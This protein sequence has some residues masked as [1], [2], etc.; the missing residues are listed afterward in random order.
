MKKVRRNAVLNVAGNVIP[1]MAA[2]AAMPMLLNG[3]GASRMGI[4]TLAL[5]LFGFAGIFD[6]GLGRALTRTIAYYTQLG[7]AA[8]RIAP[9]LRKGLFAVLIMGL[10]WAT[11]LA[12]GA[13]WLLA[14]VFSLSG[15]LHDETRRGL[16]ILTAL[17]PIA[18][19]STSLQGALEG[20]QQFG[21]S[22]IIRAPVGVAT[23]LLPALVAQVY[24]SLVAV[25]ASLAIVRFC[26]MV[27][28]LF[29]VVGQ[30]PLLA[31]TG[32]EPLSMATMWRYTGWLSISNIVGPLMVYGDRYYL[33]SILPP[34]A[35]SYYTVP[36]DTLFR[37][38]ALPGS[39]L[40][41]A[42]PALTDAQSEPGNARRFLDDAG[43]LLFFAW[44]VP[45]SL[46]AVLLPDAL[47][48]WLGEAHAQQM[49]GTSRL[50]LTGVLVNGYALVPFTLLQAIGRTDITAKLHVIEL[51]LFAI[52]LV[53]L[54]SVHG[55]EGA[56]AA[57]GLRVGFDAA[58]LFYVAQRLFPNLSRSFGRL[59]L[60]AGGGAALVLVS[61]VLPTPMLRLGAGLIILALAGLEFQRRGGVRW[62]MALTGARQ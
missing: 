7:V 53:A 61:G 34:A 24:P 16:M 9:L 28:L 39:A 29:A 45:I 20:L 37:A 6:L 3:L 1:M 11:A 21:R 58:C 8:A 10:A 5:G 41:A 46:L 55:V 51:P 62:F 42:F 23:F 15:P 35:V 31:K 59:G 26:G 40:G 22:N 49:L 44:F 4:F 13:D 54:V 36:L 50:I 2:V 56:A 57:W 17:V 38:T 52:A 12:M 48:L 27:A 33:A 32:P 25:I 47:S 19:L 60:F 14:H 30:I 18:L 43:A